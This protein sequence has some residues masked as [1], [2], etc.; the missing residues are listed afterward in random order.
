MTLDA[1]LSQSN[2]ANV[3]RLILDAYKLGVK[4]G[5]ESAF[6]GAVGNTIFA[7]DGRIWKLA[8]D[9]GG[10]Y[11]PLTGERID[12]TKPQP[13]PELFKA[14]LANIGVEDDGA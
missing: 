4:S 7:N 10:V 1:L 5:R 11:N 13:S 6:S 2:D 14:M 8:A 12:G 3:K 9:T